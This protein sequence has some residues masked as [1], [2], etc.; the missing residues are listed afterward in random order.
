MRGA[1]LPRSLSV[2]LVCLACLAVSGCGRSD[3][4]DGKVYHQDGF[5][6]VTIEFKNGKATVEL[7]GQAKTFDYKV[8]GDKVT[9]INK[10]E[11]NLELTYHSDGTLTGAMGTLRASG[12]GEA[13]AAGPAESPSAPFG[14]SGVQKE[15]GQ[16][17]MVEIRKHWT[18]GADGWITAYNSGNAFAPN[19]LRQLR[20][21]TVAGVEPSD[22][23]ESD[24]MNGVQ[25]AGEV[26]FKKGPSREAGDAGPVLADWGG[27]VMRGKG[28][29]SQW[30]DMTPEQIQALK[31][32]GKWQFQQQTMLLQGTMPNMSD[33]QTAGVRP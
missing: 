22:L 20:E 15:A 5:G 8:E 27:G 19:Y 26:T 9:I 24:K 28:R 6:A 30:V 11:G 21:I 23:S 33:F 25:W 3:P 2:L 10:E 31:V 17:V 29:W 1:H 4:V 12:A 7:M 14:M 32:N 13:T 16:A 18:K